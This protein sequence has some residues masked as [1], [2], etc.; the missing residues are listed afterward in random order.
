MG[1]KTK[2]EPKSKVIPH[3]RLEKPSQGAEIDA[4]RKTD[5]QT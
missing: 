5:V 4:H 3:N 2:D 1:G